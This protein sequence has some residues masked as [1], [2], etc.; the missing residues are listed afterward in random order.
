M[1]TCVK[2]NWCQDIDNNEK[3]MK[4]EVDALNGGF[5]DDELKGFKKRIPCFGEFYKY[6]QWHNM[7]ILT[8]HDMK[9]PTLVLHYSSY[10]TMFDETVGKIL[11]FLELERTT[12][13]LEFI[14]GKTYRGYF[15][16]DEV[17][18][19]REMATEL[20]SPETWKMIRQYFE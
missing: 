17:D 2:R 6:I 10:E 16:K 9:L 7:A 4:S 15:T 20:A 13:P 1:K 11:N 3:F 12:K 8:T 19:V 18:A 5:F 14:G